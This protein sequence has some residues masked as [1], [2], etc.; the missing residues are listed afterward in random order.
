LTCYRSQLVD[1]QPQGKPSVIES[2]CHRTRYWGHLVGVSHAEPFAS[3]EPVGLSS[4]DHLL[5]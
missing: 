2:V 5:P 3:R 1:N 4:L